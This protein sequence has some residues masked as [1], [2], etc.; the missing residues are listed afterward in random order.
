MKIISLKSE[1]VKRI[2]A[3][4]ITP[5]GN[6][7]KITG[8]NG[9]GKTSVLDSIFWALAGKEA[10]QSMPIRKGADKAM[11]EI[12]LG[13]YKVVRNITSKGAYLKVTSKD[14]ASYPS[15][16]KLLDKLVGRLSFDP[17][18]F[19]RMK[20]QAQGAVLRDLAGLDLTKIDT[21]ESQLC[22]QRRDAN[23]EAERTASILTAA[24]N[25]AVAPDEL[26]SA[27]EI[28]EELERAMKNNQTLDQARIDQV[29][30]NSAC[31]GAEEQIEEMQN[32]GKHIAETAAKEIE[33]I[34]A[35]AKEHVAAIGE[36][37]VHL[38]RN[39]VE[40]NDLAETLDKQVA[41]MNEIKTD[42]IKVRL[43]EVEIQNEAYRARQLFL[44][45][46]DN[47]NAAAKI[48][49]TLDKK[50]SSIRAE[51]KEMIVTASYPL[52]GLTI[53]DDGCVLYNEIPIDQISLAEQIRVS[54]SIAIALNPNL[55]VI[56]I[57]DGS[58][59]DSNSLDII[60]ALA[61]DNDYQVWIESVDETGE[62]GFYIEDGQLAAIDG[63]KV[64]NSK[65]T[66]ES[67]Q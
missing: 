14:G 42:E 41:S 1:N 40:A 56:R 24:D 13:D 6:I 29:N 66:E 46:V 5:D 4:E 22:D 10:I 48:A 49:E 15:P 67:E 43:A 38:R 62:V 37:V 12:D 32:D 19:T 61:T 33:Q 58:L 27:V 31:L 8:K 26:M 45:A 18:E 21:Q 60:S 30:A 3:I 54:T 23:R 7:V 47:K 63:E 17:M 51:R 34:E 16:Q 65:S 52:D 9:E 44:G 2:K 59:L 57:T 11:I 50:V 35:R 39:L 36:R 53:S 55:R 28:N 25:P 20:P 64:D